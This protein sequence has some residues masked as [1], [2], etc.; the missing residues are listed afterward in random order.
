V[1]SVT[2]NGG[3]IVVQG[4]GNL[5]LV[6]IDAGTGDVTLASAS[7]SLLDGI[8]GGSTK[9]NRNVIAGTTTLTAANRAGTP[10]DPLWVSDA[11]TVTAAGG[12]WINVPPTPY[13]G[14]PTS[15][16]I[17]PVTV[18]SADS[19]AQT[20]PPQQLPI[21]LIGQPVRLAPPI[22]VTAES[23]GISLPTGADAAAAQQDATMGTASDPISGGNED[24]IGRKK[25]TSLRSDNN[26]STQ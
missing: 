21:T 3:D 5:R 13:P 26:K 12:H 11:Y 14:L 22:A 8:A 10:I 19:T 6:S 25:K 15:D 9:S 24:E 17:S 4:Q 20:E 18:F 1:A 2:T 23:L 7:G 16:T